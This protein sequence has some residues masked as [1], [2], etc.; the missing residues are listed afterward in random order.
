MDEIWGSMLSE[1]SDT[2]KYHMI[3]FIHEIKNKAK[4]NQAHRYRTRTGGCQRQRVEVGKMS[5][6]GSK[7]T[8]FQL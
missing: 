5:E 8:N 2:D 1:M 4:T 6:R 3:S 7:G